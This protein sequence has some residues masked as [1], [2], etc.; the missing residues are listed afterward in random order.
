MKQKLLDD[1]ATIAKSLATWQQQ[2]AEATRQIAVHQGHLERIDI[3]LGYL[4]EPEG[5]ETKQEPAGR[6]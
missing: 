3:V 4:S 2:L 1:K 6:G 5:Q